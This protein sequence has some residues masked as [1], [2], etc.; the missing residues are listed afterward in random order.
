MAFD[1]LYC[2]HHDLTARPLRDRRP[3]LEDVIANN[4]LAF[5]VRRQ[6]RIRVTLPATS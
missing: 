6:R 3:R 1:L 4:D 2:D 5:P